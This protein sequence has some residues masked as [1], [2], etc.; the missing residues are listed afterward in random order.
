[1]AS[2][3][4]IVHV[5]RCKDCIH[6]DEYGECEMREYDKV[7]PCEFCWWGQT[8]NGREP[9]ELDAI[10]V[11]FLEKLRENAQNEEA[12]LMIAEI[13]VQ[14]RIRGHGKENND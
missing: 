7:K 3:Y 11:D 12:A 4:D 14:W 8:A 1:M 6:Y 5:V 2:E 9:I 10:P 13:I